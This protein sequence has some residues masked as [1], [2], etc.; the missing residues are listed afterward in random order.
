MVAAS[1]FSVMYIVSSLECG[2]L[3]RSS[4]RVG[5]KM[6][7]Y[8]KLCEVCL[9]RSIALPVELLVD[10]WTQPNRIQPGCKIVVAIRRPIS[11]ALRSLIT[12]GRSSSTRKLSHNWYELLV[13]YL[14]ASDVDGSIF[15]NIQCACIYSLQLVLLLTTIVLR[16]SYLLDRFAQ[17][18]ARPFGESIEAK[19]RTATGPARSWKESCQ[20]LQRKE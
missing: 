19:L 11:H 10:D 12:A 2:L 13:N 17:P 16:S 5:K 6:T 14:S 4:G 7:K 20:L 15:P 9:T 8:V 3:Q 18:P 1:S